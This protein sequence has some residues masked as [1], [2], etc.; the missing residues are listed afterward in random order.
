M[1]SQASEVQFGGYSVKLTG[2]PALSANCWEAIARTI[3]ETC[4]RQRACRYLEWGSGNSTLSVTSEALSN[5]RQV[6]IVSIEHHRVF[7]R[8]LA[9][10]LLGVCGRLVSR[11]PP[12]ADKITL[13][14]IRLEGPYLTPASFLGMARRVRALESHFMKWQHFTGNKHITES[15]KGIPSFDIGL[16]RIVKQAVKYRLSRLNFAL[17]KLRGLGKGLR[18]KHAVELYRSRPIVTLTGS[19]ASPDDMQDF[20]RHIDAIQGPGKLV[21]EA[22]P[23]V[24]Q[25]YLM[26][27]QQSWFWARRSFDGLFI[28]FADYVLCPVEGQFDVIFIDGRAR[29]SCMKRVR[30]DNLLAK[31]GTLF[32]H[33]GHSVHHSEGFQ[34]LGGYAFIHGSNVMQDGTN[35]HVASRPP[36]LRMGTSLDDLTA[37]VDRELFV[38][39]KERPDW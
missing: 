14:V 5:H 12:L 35:H 16:G 18:E 17:W 22:G 39:R 25:Y 19:P 36:V 15:D 9:R 24:V 6:E 2:A 30:C 38:F 29:V 21:I 7:Y 34:A 28:E 31:D 4:G 8:T 32:V 1:R 33:D 11:D 37:V 20:V 10:E 27:Q 3:R 13:R 26:P 23:V